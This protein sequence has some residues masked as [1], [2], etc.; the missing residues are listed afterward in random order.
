MFKLIYKSCGC[1]S[2]KFLVYRII[3]SL[4]FGR[5]SENLKKRCSSLR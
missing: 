3:L 2:E 5:L 4:H 1:F